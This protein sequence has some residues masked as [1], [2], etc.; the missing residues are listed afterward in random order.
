WPPGLRALRPGM[1]AGR[2]DR[3]PPAR[4]PREERH[5]LGPSYPWRRI[6]RLAASTARARGIPVRV[7][8]RTR[9]AD[10]AEGLEYVVRQDWRTRRHAVPHSP[11]HAAAR[12]RLQAC[13]RWARYPS[14]AA[15]SRSQEHSAHGSVQRTCAGP[16]QEFLAALDTTSII[17]SSRPPRLAAVSI[18]GRPHG[19]PIPGEDR[20]KATCR[21][22]S[23]GMAA[24]LRGWLCWRRSRWCCAVPSVRGHST[25]L[26]RW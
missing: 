22:P 4:P 18:S 5:A 17:T 24:A 8:L 9:R 25:R 14:L 6:A 3:R 20:P 12:L 21:R 13:K 11:A 15:L 1:V 23:D 26:S 19:P 16:I 10:D 2:V 7:L